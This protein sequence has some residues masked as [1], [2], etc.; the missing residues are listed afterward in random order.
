MKIYFTEENKQEYFRCVN[1]IIDT[2]WWSDGKYTRNFEQMNNDYCGM[3]S[4]ALSNAG[5]ALYMLYKYAGVKGKD[6]IIPGNT[7]WATASTAKLAGANVIYADCNKEDLCLSY[8]D[9][10]K[11]V[12]KNTAAITVVH[13]GGHIAFDIEKIAKFCSENNIALIEDCAH[14]HGAEWNGRKAGSWGIGGAYSF[15][16][17]KTLSTGEGGLLV[18]KNKELAEW[19]KIQ[20]NYGKKL[21]DNKITYPHLDGF[22]FRMSEFTAALGCIQM[23]NLEDIIAQKRALASKYDKIFDN[24]VHFPE[25]MKSGYYKYIIFNQDLKQ[26]TGKVFGLT[27]QCSYIEAKNHDL[28]NSNWVGENH[29]CPPIYNN[30]EHAEKS[31]DEIA[32]ILIKE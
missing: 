23:S 11:R 32:D 30:W 28:P 24:R 10:V 4:V 18:T 17:T 12:T 22:N 5:A 21:V 9:M 3:E 16:A 20:R 25:G 14:A 15:Y 13:I 26:Q 6:V 7:F 19:C 27:D 2:N 31:I 1:E 29:Y 8:N